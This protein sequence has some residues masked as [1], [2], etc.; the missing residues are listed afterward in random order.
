MRKNSCAIYF[1]ASSW[2]NFFCLTWGVL[3]SML[4][5]I[6]N[7]N[8]SNYSDVYCK[9]RNYMINFS[10]FSSRAFII[11]A[12]LDRFLLCSTSVRQRQFCRPI[13]AIKMVVFAI[14]ICAC[15]PIYILISY[16]SH[17]IIMPCM[18]TTQAANIYETISI[19]MLS[20]TIPTLSM[21]ILSWLTI[22]RLKTNA[23]R[24]GREKI[25]VDGKDSQLTTML[26]AQVLLYMVTNVPYFIFIFYA[27]INENVP[28]S[29]KSLYRITIE[30]F[31]ATLLTSFFY[32]VFNGWSFF[33]YTLT[34]PSFRRELLMIF[35]RLCLCKTPHIN[36]QH[37]RTRS[38]RIHP[39]NQDIA[40]IN[41][42]YF[43]NH[44]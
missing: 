29:S 28:T 39:I 41:P 2:A 13:I 27:K 15:L 25:R 4:A 16:K 40:T 7:N 35:S 44:E 43:I 22:K 34:A 9:I 11:L 19:W 20:V 12:C 23:K 26:I 33:V 36:N 32:Y 24:V 6:T 37:T 3:A 10:Q 30:S 5:F 42:T 21:S 1:H 18:V 31:S 8:P 38:G 17:Q 14:L